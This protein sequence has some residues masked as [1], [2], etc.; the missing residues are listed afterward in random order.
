MERFFE[1]KPAFPK[2]SHTG[3]VRLTKVR[4]ILERPA[5]A[6]YVEAP[7]WGVSL[8]MGH[9]EAH[10]S[11]DTHQRVLTRLKGN[12]LAPARKDI[13]ADFP[14]RGFVC[15]SD[16]GEPMTSCWSKGKLRHYA[17][18]L[19]DTRGCPSYRKS[20][21]R[22]EIEEGAEQILRSLQ[23]ARQLVNLARALFTDLWQRRLTTAERDRDRLLADLRGIEKQTD[24]L[25][26]RLVDAA[27]A[28]VVQAYEEKIEKLERRK[29]DLA[30]QA[31]QT[32]PPEGRYEEVIEHAVAFLANPWDAYK[33]GG[34]VLKRTV[35]KLA[36]TAPPRYAREEGYRTPAIAFPFRVLGRVL[37]RK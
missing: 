8:R 29:I 5:Y 3:T 12:L 18:Y 15:C 2:S 32:L 7:N 11:W 37:T 30:E 23:P 20:I 26:D 22:A 4:E 6:G 27:D 16:C 19:C 35:L 36:L 31:A 28:T 10:I 14:L 25:L 13:N 24:T 17:Y 21:P 33:K 34:L 1:A 9:H